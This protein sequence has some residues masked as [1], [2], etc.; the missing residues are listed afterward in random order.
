[1]KLYR[2]IVGVYKQLSIIR[3]A[4]GEIMAAGNSIYIFGDLNMLEASE[5]ISSTL[6]ETSKTQMP[7]ALYIL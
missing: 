7:H 2:Q 6:Q 1:M 5:A 4:A 3:S